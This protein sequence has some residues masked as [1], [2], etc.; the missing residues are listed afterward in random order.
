M[1]GKL[2]RS[3]RAQ[4]AAAPANPAPATPANASASPQPARTAT[5]TAA[6][7]SAATTSATT[8]ATATAAPSEVSDA[9]A[10]ANA[11]AREQ[12]FAQAILHYQA[13]LRQKGSQPKIYLG[14][15]YALLQTGELERA[16]AAL[17]N[18][19]TLAPGD[20]EALFLHGLVCRLR[21]LPDQAAASWRKVH[22]LAPAFA[23][24]YTELCLLLVERGQLAQAEA[25]MRAAVLAH[26]GEADFHFYLG[27][28]LSS[29]GRPLEAE[30]CYRA[31]LA[32]TP[33]AP[34][35]LSNLSNALR[36]LGRL[37][38]SIATA[39]ESLRLLPDNAKAFSNYL[40]S[41]QYSDKFSREEKFQEHLRYAAQFE[42]PLKAHW[43]DHSARPRREGRLRVGYASADLRQHALA[44][45]IE[46]ILRRHDHS[47]FEL[48]AY[49]AHPS[50]DAVTERMHGYF[51]HWLDCAAL[52]DE[53]LA[54]RIM[55]DGIDLLVDLS[56]HTG[57]NRLLTFARKPAPVQITWLGYQ[58]TTGLQAM[59]YRITDEG[60]DPS[61]SGDAFFTEKLLR[62]FTSASFEASADSPPVGPLPVL[63]GAP[64]CFGCLNNPSKIGD[65]CIAVWS[66]VLLRCP[67]AS[68]MLGS[69]TPEMMDMFAARFAAHGVDAARLRFI[70]K[71]AL[72]DYLA[73]HHQI[74]LALDTFPY[75]GGTTTFH[76][77]W[78][79]VPV[80][81]LRGDSSLSRAGVAIMSG[82]GLNDYCADDEAAYIERAVDFYTNPQKLLPARE[83]LREKMGNAANLNAQQFTQTLEQTYLDCWQAR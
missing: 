83:T 71:L 79:G 16:Q 53:A 44:F 51:D 40:F 2:L 58:A 65:N 25:L 7:T 22:T 68:L 77:L 29:L 32:I 8:L 35:V 45:F 48:F 74:D 5:T 13:A 64:F 82:L 37:D 4:P 39:R 66:R 46:P 1:F 20:V 14:L 50:S 9:L 19:V 38:E 43:P 62:L 80:L 21:G 34:I 41:L 18:A 78:M 6:T 27:N 67:D 60:L 70:P 56:G 36:E 54:Q 17:A 26:P 73:L 11:A 10:L 49:Y 63:A 75:N 69:A 61:G 81:A 33:Q 30:P 23:P 28:V 3:L 55:D 12:N 52:T 76:S 15:G 31:A 57:N 59:D 72:N 42:A 47:R 24:V